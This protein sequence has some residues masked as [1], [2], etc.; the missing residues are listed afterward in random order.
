[1]VVGIK[2]EH[3]GVTNCRRDV[4]GVVSQ[5]ATCADLHRVN[6]SSGERGK[7]QYKG[8]HKDIVHRVYVIRDAESTAKIWDA[9]YTLLDPVM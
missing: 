5:H 8:N 3:D 1:M 6:S 9:L 7:C 4:L 2:K